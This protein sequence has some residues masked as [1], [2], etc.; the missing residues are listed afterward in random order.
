M[1]RKGNGKGNGCRVVGRGATFKPQHWERQEGSFP[2][3]RTFGAS[4]RM[5]NMK[6]RLLSAAVR[7]RRGKEK[8]PGQGGK[9]RGAAPW[10]NISHLTA[11][12][13]TRGSSSSRW[14]Q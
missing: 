7:C 11:T 10:K 4:L 8:P 5:K 12:S 1:R 9:K 2:P 3:R 14:V 13:A 6:A